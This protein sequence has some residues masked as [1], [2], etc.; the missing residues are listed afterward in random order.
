MG[1]LCHEHYPS[2]VYNLVV[3]NIRLNEVKND[4]KERLE[5]GVDHLFSE[6]K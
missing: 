4:A 5:Y 3:D 6:E 2:N 1:G